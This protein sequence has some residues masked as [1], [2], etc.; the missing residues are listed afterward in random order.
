MEDDD[1]WLREELWKLATINEESNVNMGDAMVIL[2]LIAS[3]DRSG[4]WMVV[5]FFAG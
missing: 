1:C 2:E 3:W 5:V 4:R